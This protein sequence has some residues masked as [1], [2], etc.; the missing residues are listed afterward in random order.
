MMNR[1]EVV[2]LQHQRY[3]TKKFDPARR[4]SDEDWAALVEVGRLAPSSL[5]FEPWKMLLL[6]N[7]EMK[8]DL[9]SMAWGAVSMLDGASHFVI[10]LAR[11]GVNYETPY[12]EKLMQEVRHRSYDPDSAYAHR[13]KS[14]QESDAKLNDE[15]SL[16]DWASKQTYIQMTN[17]MNAAVLM[18]MDSCPI[19]GFDKDKVEAYLEEKGVLDTSEFGVSVMCAFGYRDEEI[20]PKVCWNTES[21][22][23]VID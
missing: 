3:A 2:A 23:E 7:K 10:Y 22:Y 15:R 12:I 17:M 14:F 9:K 16:F 8:Q 18:G 19:E 5:G 21:I 13:I 11:K 4:I 6:N 20:K 1:E